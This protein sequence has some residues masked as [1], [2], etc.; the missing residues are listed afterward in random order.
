MKKSQHAVM[1]GLMGET[2]LLF[3]S[4]SSLSFFEGMALCDNSNAARLNLNH[5]RTS[6]SDTF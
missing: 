5:P 1:R 3:H 2:P 6:E 4:L